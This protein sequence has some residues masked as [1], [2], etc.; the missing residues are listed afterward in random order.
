MRLPEGKQ[1]KTIFLCLS[2]SKKGEME[3]FAAINLETGAG[4]ICNGKKRLSATIGYSVASITRRMDEGSLF[5][6]KKW[7]VTN[8]VT[9]VKQ[10]KPGGSFGAFT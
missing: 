5:K 8:D 9:L 4:Y 6:Y 10:K 7:V 3:Q 1:T 2:L